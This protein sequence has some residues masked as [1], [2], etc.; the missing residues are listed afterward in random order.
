MRPTR[1]RDFKM[2]KVNYLVIAI[3]AISFA[4]T[5]CGG[6]SG[7]G[8]GNIVMKAETDEMSFRMAG[9]GK[10]T[11]DW[12]DGTRE[13]HEV[14]DNSEFKHEY[15][16]RSVRTITIKGKI[17]ELIC[18]GRGLTSLDVS[19]STALTK[20]ECGGN[21]LTSLDVSKSTALTTLWC[22][23][24]QLTSL[25]VSKSTALTK[26]WCNNN[27]LTNLDVSKNT[28][29]TKL[30]CYYN[31]LTS[32]DVSK[33]TALTELECGSNQLTSL[34]V[35]KNTAL[36]VLNC[37][38]NQLDASALNNLFGTLPKTSGEI[39]VFGNPGERDCDQSIAVSKGWSVR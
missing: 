22:G 14:G 13:T 33:N 1:I 38:Y 25:D 39:V 21:Q 7:G 27:Q 3:L 29:L 20:L 9:S 10:V 30:E 11:I 4:F 15:S 19:K 18:G 31:Q 37:Y 28:A 32:L 8:K 36:K 24:N 26:L 16:G 6:G 12:G 34:D 23:G 5:S 2:K 17:T 35:S